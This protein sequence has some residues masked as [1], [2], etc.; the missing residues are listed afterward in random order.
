MLFHMDL[1]FLL[2]FLC[3]RTVRAA[4]IAATVTLPG[5]VQHTPQPPACIT[6]AGTDNQPYNNFFQGQMI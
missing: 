6:H 5:W 3:Q 2:A 1:N 4:T